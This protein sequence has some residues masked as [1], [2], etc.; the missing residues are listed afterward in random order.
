MYIKFWGV[1]GSLPRPGPKTLKYGG[2]TPCVEVRCGDT[3]LILD[4]GTGI[5][6]LGDDLLARADR[7]PDGAPPLEAFILISHFHWDHVQGIAFF[8]PAFVKGARFHVYGVADTQRNIALTLR[9]QLAKPNFPLTCDDFAAHFSFHDIEPGRLISIGDASVT[10]ATL[11]HPGGSYAFRIEHGGRSFV[12]A[13]DTEHLDRIDGDLLGLASKAD[14][15]VYDG[16]FSPDQYVGL[17]DN[18][19]R[20][21]WGHSTWEAAVEVARAAEVG[22]LILFHHGNEDSVVEQM[23]SEARKCFPRTR[24]AFEGLEIRL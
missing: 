7:V 18:T 14:V 22:E 13:S 9:N 6:E 16:M 3:L 10:T 4:A 15:L 24:A 21:N 19:P 20:K 1:H 2:N 5:R 17:W 11:N 8:A 23:E 12:Y